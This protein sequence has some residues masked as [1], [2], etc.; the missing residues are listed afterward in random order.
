MI[1]LIFMKCIRKYR[2]NEFHNIRDSG[3]FCLNCSTTLISESHD[4]K[5]LLELQ[6]FQPNS[7]QQGWR[8]KRRKAKGDFRWFSSFLLSRLSKRHNTIAFYI[9]LTRQSHV[10]S[11]LYPLPRESEKCSILSLLQC[12]QNL[13]TWLLF[14]WRTCGRDRCWVEQLGGLPH[15][16]NPIMGS[17]AERS[18]MWTYF[19]HGHCH[20]CVIISQIL[21]LSPFHTFI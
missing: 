8:R 14:L 11:W 15:S 5:W 9:S 17:D 2:V 1:F 19:V 10:T 21:V 3:F 7:R 12:T 6:L 13:D 20:V 18:Q 16:Y 4:P